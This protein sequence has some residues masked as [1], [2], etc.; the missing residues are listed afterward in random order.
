MNSFKKYKTLFSCIS[1]LSFA[2]CFFPSCNKFLDRQ[3]LGQYTQDNYPYP[4]G[5]GR[6]DQYIYA[7]Y[8]DLRDYRVSSYAFVAALLR[9][10]DADVGSVD[11]DGSTYGV[12]QADNFTLTPT[13][14]FCNDLWVGYTGLINYANIVL[15]Q[16]GEDTSN[17]PQATKTLATAEARFIRGYAYFTFVRLFGNVPL[18]DTVLTVSASNIPQ[19]D[20]ATIYAFIE[21]DLQYAAAN[22]PAQWPATFIG[23][24]T[25]GSANGLLAKVYLYEKNWSQAMSTANLVINS[26]AYDLTTPYDKIFTQEGENTKESVFEIQCYSSIQVPI[27][28]GCQYANVQGVRG[29]STQDMGWGFNDPSKQ[30]EQAYEAGDPREEATIIRCPGTVGQFTS[31]GWVYEIF[32]PEPDTTYNKKVYLNPAVRSAVGGQG[33]YYGWGIDLRI[34]RYSDVLLMY[35]EAAN[36]LGQTDSALSKLEMVRAR[37]RNGNNAILPPITTTDQTQLR[38]AIRHERMVE[39]AMEFD[40]FFDLVR[41]GI[42]ADVLHAAGKT[43]FKAGRDEYLPIPQAQIDLSKGVLHQNPGF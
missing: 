15:Q 4:P 25:S 24:A 10:D 23:R 7:A 12:P 34:L 13:A 35:A 2:I 5:S 16:V 33:Y 1:I 26:G 27:N 6:Y 3:P 40:R 30:L 38:L 17:T 18:I 9:S 31:T 37:A 42:A 36:E 11:F 19:S 39:L 43:N 8:S 32:G 14:Q 22:L 21:Q 29:V 41:W 20:S 28:Y